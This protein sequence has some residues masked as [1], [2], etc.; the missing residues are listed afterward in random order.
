MKWMS[1]IL[2][3]LGLS[4]QA[5]ANTTQFFYQA[6]GGQHVFEPATALGVISVE[7]PNTNNT[8]INT[9]LSGAYEYGFM[10]GLAARIRLGYASSF[11][12]T[13]F[14]NSTSTDDTSTA[15]GLEDIEISL[16]GY[17]ALG[18]TATIRYGLDIGWSPQP[19]KFD[20]NGNIDNQMTGQNDVTPYAGVDFLI[21]KRHRVGGKLQREFLL[22]DQ[23]DENPN[24]TQA[25]F[26]GGEW[27]RVGAFYE[28]NW[29]S[30]L[31]K[32]FLD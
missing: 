25:R 5:Q 15:Q 32:G 2:F 10:D 21:A 1:I 17:A 29:E 30:G 14:P 27:T 8:T 28:F 19:N 3:T 11:R 24:G 4:L 6:D 16:K 31:L 22:G 20:T 26:K 13:E 23:I 7:T 9:G 12:R 18:S